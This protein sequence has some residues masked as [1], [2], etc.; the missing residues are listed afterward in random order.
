MR[1]DLSFDRSNSFKSETIFSLSNVDEGGSQSIII[2]GSN[3]AIKENFR[4]DCG[5]YISCAK[6][7]SEYL[8]RED[9]LYASEKKRVL[10]YTIRPSTV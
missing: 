1:D 5:V 4:P 9:L 2:V 7:L 3:A 6:V 10:Q 8:R